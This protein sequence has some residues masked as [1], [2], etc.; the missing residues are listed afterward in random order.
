[1]LTGSSCREEEIAMRVLIAGAIGRPL[2]RCL[3]E[4]G[5][6]AFALARSP[7]SARAIAALGA[8]PAIADALDAGAV[9]AAIVQARPEAVI[10]ELTSLPRHYTASEMAAAAERDRQVRTERNKKPACRP[11]RGRCPP[12][13]AAELGVLV[14]AGGRPRR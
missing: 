12:L 5:H 14:R 6:T 8:E 10:N 4:R 11:A 13:P 2:I 1:M 7:D 3:R 9:K